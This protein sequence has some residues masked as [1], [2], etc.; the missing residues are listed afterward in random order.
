MMTV[1]V[2]LRNCLLL[3]VDWMQNLH[4]CFPDANYSQTVTHLDPLHGYAPNSRCWNRFLFSYALAMQAT[5]VLLDQNRPGSR[6]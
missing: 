2:A 3:L 4:Q 5:L 1:L 6:D